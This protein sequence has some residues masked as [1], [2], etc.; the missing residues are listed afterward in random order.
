[1]ILSELPV[2]EYAFPGELRDRLLA[3]L[4]SGAK[5]TTTSLHEAYAV[6]DEPI[7]IAGTVQA[8][9]DSAGERVFATEIVSVE[10]MPMGQVSDAFAIAEGEGFANARQW[11]AA[12]EA[13]WLSE[14]SVEDLGYTPKL[15]DDTLVVCETVRVLSAEELASL[16][17]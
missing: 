16:T 11:R 2:S 10:V 6:W 1:M 5:T 4:L 12:H 3:A 9:I 15:S 14:A 8:V 17:A 7:P 13:Y